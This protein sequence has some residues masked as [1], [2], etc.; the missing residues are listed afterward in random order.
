MVAGIL[1]S[2]AGMTN[3]IQL[4]GGSQDETVPGAAMQTL[5]GLQGATGGTAA[6]A[7]RALT[8]T[9]LGVAEGPLKQLSGTFSVTGQS[10]NASINMIEGTISSPFSVIQN[11]SNVARAQGATTLT[12]DASIAN[13]RLLD[14]LVNRY[15]A[16]TIGG[17]EKL[18]IPLY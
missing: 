4:A 7:S 17:G 6:T 18:V 9:D 13:P 11:L 12:I 1:N 10:A 15:G 3:S 14:I 8:A 2:M 16:Q 5:R